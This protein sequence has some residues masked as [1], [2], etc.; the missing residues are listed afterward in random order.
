ME[1]NK[2][3]PKSKMNDYYVKSLDFTV[4]HRTEAHT[5]CPL[6]VNVMI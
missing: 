2:E 4:Q 5:K 3:K 6:T 1:R